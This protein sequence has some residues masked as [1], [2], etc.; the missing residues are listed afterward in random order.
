MPVYGVLSSRCIQPATRHGAA[1]ADYLLRDPRM[2]AI[3]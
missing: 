1:Q 2:R 3:A